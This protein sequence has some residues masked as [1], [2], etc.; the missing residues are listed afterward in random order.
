LRWSILHAPGRL[1]R[2]ARPHIVRII[3][4]W[5]TADALLHAYR[6]INLIT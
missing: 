2:T 5:P 1:I 3:D 6:R 4:N